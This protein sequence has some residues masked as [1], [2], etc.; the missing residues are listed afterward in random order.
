MCEANPMLSNKYTCYHFN[1]HQRKLIFEIKVIER[2]VHN[3]NGL[4]K[5]ASLKPGLVPDSYYHSTQANT[6]GFQAQR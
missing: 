5:K 2:C 1:L 3:L 6:I 4:E